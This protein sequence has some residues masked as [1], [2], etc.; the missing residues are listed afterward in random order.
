VEVSDCV[1]GNPAGE[2]DIPALPGNGDCKKQPPK[3]EDGLKKS[4]TM[5][6]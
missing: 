2:A 3:N 6:Q 4:Q 5:K 1:M